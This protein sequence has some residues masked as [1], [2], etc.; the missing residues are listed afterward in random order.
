M[1]KQHLFS[2]TSLFFVFMLLLA[3]KTSKPISTDGTDTTDNNYTE[4][5]AKPVSMD[6]SPTRKVPKPT[7]KGTNETPYNI[8]SVSIKENTESTKK[9]NEQVLPASSS[10]KNTQNDKMEA[11]ISEMSL[12]NTAIEEAQGYKLQVYSGSDRLEA[13][14]ILKKLKSWVP[15]SDQPILVYEQ[16]NYKIKLGNFT[17]KLDAY[18]KFQVLVKEFP[19]I[20]IV[21]DLINMEQLRKK[22]QQN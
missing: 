21:T 14:K 22:Y 12:A 18:Y 1:M 8:S 16:P 17:N 9:P 15:A 2:Y 11:L 3:C 7:K 4:T 20:L 19:T 5:T 10:L 6:L 13:E